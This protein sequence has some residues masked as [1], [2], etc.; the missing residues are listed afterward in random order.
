V[1]PTEYFPNG[2]RYS[3]W[4][5]PEEAEQERREEY[6]AE[7][8]GATPFIGM[9]PYR[10]LKGLA[11]GTITNYRVTRVETGADAEARREREAREANET[12]EQK[13]EKA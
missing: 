3:P 13:D 5:T 10:I 1:S 7:D 6:E 4:A 12:S 2:G 8:R 11:D 9:P